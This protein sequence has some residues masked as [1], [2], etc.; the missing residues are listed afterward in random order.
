MAASIATV[1]MP[2]A[3]SPSTSEPDA[4]ICLAGP[5]LRQIGMSAG[6]SIKPAPCTVD[7]AQ[8]HSASAACPVGLVELVWLA[9]RLA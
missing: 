3:A 9:G 5:A 7:M 6:T 2:T 1:W 4:V 8:D